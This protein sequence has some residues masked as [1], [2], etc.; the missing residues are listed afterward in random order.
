M[1][2]KLQLA[3]EIFVINALQ[4]MLSM[5]Q[6]KEKVI[7]KIKVKVIKVKV[8]KVKVIKVKVIKVKVID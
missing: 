5:H 4:I 2:R 3:S 7:K 1:I 6:L 8:I